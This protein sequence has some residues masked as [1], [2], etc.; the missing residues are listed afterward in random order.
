MMTKATIQKVAEQASL[1]SD[2]VA[3]VRQVA[4]DAPWAWLAAGWNDLWRSPG[5][6]LT[7]GAVFAAIASGLLLGLTLAQWQSLLP[8]MAG[9]FFLV[10][11][12]AAVGLYETSRRLAAGEPVSLAIAVAAA[13]RAPVQLGLLGV[14]LLVVFLVWMELAFVLLVLFLGGGGLPA[15]SEFMHTL[16]FT[17]AGLGLLV[18]GTV[19][20]GFL[21][22]IV[23]AISAVSV[24][25]VLFHQIDAVSA[26][27]ASV[28][29]V[30]RN[31]RPMLLW[32]ALI[33]GFV[34]L[35]FLTLLIGL[36]VVFPLI[37]HATWHAYRAVVEVSNDAS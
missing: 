3:Q 9:G 24:P 12:L 28:Q 7:Y 37:G 18:A 15:P 33:G 20:G 35:G 31:P 29:A 11:P 17:P 16:L 2:S 4:F 26:A 13:G 36:V 25:L 8:A 5:V 10:G 6:S 19:V 21:A 30:A 23:Y 34:A 27:T 14:G 32:A 1:P 22:A